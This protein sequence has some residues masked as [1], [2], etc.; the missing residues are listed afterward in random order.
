MNQKLTSQVVLEKT[1]SQTF[2]NNARYDPPAAMYTV[3][4]SDGPSVGSSMT[5]TLLIEECDDEMSDSMKR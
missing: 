4:V 2:R 1:Q 5:S 3:E